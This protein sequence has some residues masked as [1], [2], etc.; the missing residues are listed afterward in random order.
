MKRKVLIKYLLLQGC[1]L[2]REGKNHSIYINSLINKT[3]A[4]PR[5]NEINTYT[6][7][8]ICQDLEIPVINLK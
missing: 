1:I 5:H 4:V 2:Q 7:K 8:S 6:A 3:S